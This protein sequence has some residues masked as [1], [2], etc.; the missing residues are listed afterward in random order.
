VLGKV[1]QARNTKRD[2]KNSKRRQ[3]QHFFFP[4]ISNL[5]QH[6][7]FEPSNVG[8]AKRSTSSIIHDLFDEDFL[9]PTKSSTSRGGGL[10]MLLP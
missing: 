3:M 4:T 2:R 6:E 10:R 9:L 8:A 1:S 5:A 7:Q